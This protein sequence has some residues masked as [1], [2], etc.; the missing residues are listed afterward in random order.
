MAQTIE[1]TVSGNKEFGNLPEAASQTFVHGDF[2]ILDSNG[3]AQVAV[4]AGSRVGASSSG[5]TTNRIVGQAM[6]AASGTTGR[7]VQFVKAKP[8]TRFLMP[9]HHATAASAVPNT[10]QVGKVYELIHV[11]ADIDYWAV[12]LDNTT[13]V[14][15]KVVEMFP[16]DHTG[17][18]GR[19]YPTAASTT[20]YGRVWVEFIDNESALIGAEND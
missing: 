16:D 17:W 15:V 6:H 8:G 9:V 13:N 12:S 2:L 11:N 18:D 3:R 20:Q 14:K 7:Q 19:G 4:A 1:Y 10:N 5:A